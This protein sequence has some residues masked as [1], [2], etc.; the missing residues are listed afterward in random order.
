[1]INIPQ[2][3]T[4]VPKTEQ[5]LQIESIRPGFDKAFSWELRHDQIRKGVVITTSFVILRLLVAR[6]WDT[7]FG[8]AY[9]LTLPI[10]LFLFTSFIVISVGLVYFGFTYWAGI[11]IKSW[12]L[13]SGQISQDIKWGFI[14]LIVC[15]IIFLGTLFVLYLFNLIPPSLMTGTQ[16]NE[17]VEQTLAKLPVDLVL[18]WFFGFTIAAFT[19]ETIFRGF[20]MGVIADKVNPHIS[21]ILQ[22]VL[23]STSHLGMASV[24]SI[25]SEIITLL[26]RFASGWLFGWLRMKRGTLLASGTLHG[27]IG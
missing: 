16:E 4:I 9:H 15:G 25:G 17:A 27:F 12:W 14:A 18:G 6:L 2:E 19:E 8:M 10:L 26:F 13:R 5:S 11:D 1:M 20:I 23:F 24:G 21:N 7:W 3:T 22:S